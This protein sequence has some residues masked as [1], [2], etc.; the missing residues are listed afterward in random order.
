MEEEFQE[1]EVIFRETV[2]TYDEDDYNFTAHSNSLVL[3]S[4]KNP[5]RK[6][7][8]KKKNSIPVEIPQ[9]A[10]G[11][12]WF[13]CVESDFFDDEEFEDGELVPPHVLL[14]RRVAGKMAFSVC[15]GIGRT[16]K[17]RDLS[18]VRNSI[19][20]MTGFLETFAYDGVSS[21]H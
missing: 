6:K 11:N 12:S 10:Q 7:M 3:P 19:L 18:E 13:Q 20:R 5:K 15:T 2:A 4:N 9:N 14:G 8:K 16:L 1:S 17:G 21:M